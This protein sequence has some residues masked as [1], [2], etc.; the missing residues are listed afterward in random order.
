MLSESDQYIFVRE[1]IM[2]T[3]MSESDTVAA[4]LNVLMGCNGIK[5]C[6]CLFCVS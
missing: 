1:K 5:R 6:Q 4:V 2:F 3:K